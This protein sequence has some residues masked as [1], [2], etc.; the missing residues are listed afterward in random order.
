MSVFD[1]AAVLERLRALPGGRELLEVAGAR[2]D[3]ELVGGAVRD[4]ALGLKPRELDVV[5]ASEP[6]AFALELSARLAQH[7][8]RGREEDPTFYERFGT[9]V[10]SRGAIR[11]DVATRRS[12]GYPAPGALPQVRAGTPEEDLRR[13]DFTVNAIAVSLSGAGAGTPR[14]AEH[15][16][17]DLARGQL[18]VLHDASFSDDPTRLLRLAR[19]RA[20]LRFEIE[21]HTAVLARQA[22]AADAL[23][24]VSGA[25]T[26]SELRLALTEADA[27]AA[28]AAMDDLGLLAA[29]ELR[30]PDASRRDR[31]RAIERAIVLLPDDGRPDLLALAGLLLAPDAAPLPADG[32]RR[33]QIAALL[34]RFAFPAGDRDRAAAAAI[35]APRLI[36]G[37]P[38]AERPSRLR[39]LVADAPPEGVALAGGVSAR[40]A[41]PARRWLQEL[42]N[43]RLRI[44]GN[45]LRSS[46]IPEGPEIGRRLEETLRG[47]LDGDLPDEREAQLQ[48]ALR[49]LKR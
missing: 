12:E 16:L 11:I 31:W 28:L 24:T 5:V 45:D 8:G 6:Q 37:L 42:R 3:V 4:L 32:D 27:P 10:V 22:L 14:A 30:P 17:E 13:R 43:V 48:A 36:A 41:E 7:G 35:A 20:R 38:G 25:R 1:G 49:G 46:G 2:E 9:V 33:G 19:Y 39:A 23:T 21:P 34:D 29:L 40:A 18:R 15:A 26:G 47:R 44:D